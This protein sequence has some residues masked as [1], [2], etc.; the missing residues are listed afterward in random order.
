MYPELAIAMW[1]RKAL[2][3]T[4]I[5]IVHGQRVDVWQINTTVI[6]VG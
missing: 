3:I 4:G 1:S 5:T 2:S 6:V